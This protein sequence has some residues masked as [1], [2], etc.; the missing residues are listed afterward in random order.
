MP[1][2]L[3]TLRGAGGGKHEAQQRAELQRATTR[4]G[5]RAVSQLLEPHRGMQTTKLAVRRAAPT[6]NVAQTCNRGNMSHRRGAL[7]PARCGAV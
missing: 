2:I 5:E 3:L 1:A 4:T 6:A 7:I